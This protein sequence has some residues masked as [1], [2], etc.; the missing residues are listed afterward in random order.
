[1]IAKN[2]NKI[3]YSKVKFDG[4]KM[5]KAAH[6]QARVWANNGK[7]YRVNF[8]AALKAVW[9]AAK[10]AIYTCICRVAKIAQNKLLGMVKMVKNEK[11]NKADEIVKKLRDLGCKDWQKGDLH[12]IYVGYNAKYVFANYDNFGRGRKSQLHDMFF[13][14][15][16]G[17]W[18]QNWIGI[19]NPEFE[20]V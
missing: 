12:R 16:N 20:L 1:M 7:P 2:V 13:D 5:M 19:F 3:N 4:S 10:G 14:V 9:A 18:S 15:A 8:A 6:S 11:T 17:C